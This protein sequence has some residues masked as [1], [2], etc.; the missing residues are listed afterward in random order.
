[1]SALRVRPAVANDATFLAEMLAVAADW[2]PGSM[3]RPVASVLAD[4]AIAHY[5]DGWPRHTDVGVVA[6][7]DGAPVGAAWW[8]FLPADDPGYGF[9]D[10]STPEISIGVRVDQ[11]GRG[12]GT[13]LLSEL[14]RTADG[15]RLETTSLSVEVDNPAVRLYLRAGFEVLATSDGAHTMVRRRPDPI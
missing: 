9:V 2:R 5:V 4:P 10:V 3:A 6:E 7:S 15:A 8:R 13:A 14:L 1:V 12:V 11:R